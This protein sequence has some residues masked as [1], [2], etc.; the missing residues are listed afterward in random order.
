MKRKSENAKTARNVCLLLGI[1]AIVGLCAAV[2]YP[3][4]A[5][6]ARRT[7]SETFASA[8]VP[9]APIAAPQTAITVAD[10]P[11]IL[12]WNCP[13]G[14]CCP[15]ETV[16]VNVSPAPQPAGP[17]APVNVSVEPAPQPPFPFGVLLA[18]LIPVILISSVLAFVQR[19]QTGG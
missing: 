5:A 17:V 19:V 12:P 1:L 6:F 11:C 16:N 9:P 18:V 7:C 3:C 8:T 10:R 13:K 15:K 14:K 2:A 4:G